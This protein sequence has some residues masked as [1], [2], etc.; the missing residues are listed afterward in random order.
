[1]NETPGVQPSTDVSRS[2]TESL[3]QREQLTLSQSYPHS[4]RSGYAIDTAI[5]SIHNGEFDARD[6]HNNLTPDST[7]PLPHSHQL[8]SSPTMV[9]HS[10]SA[11]ASSLSYQNIPQHRSLDGRKEG[12]IEEDSSEDYTSDEQDQKKAWS[13]Y[14]DLKHPHDLEDPFS[15]PKGISPRYSYPFPRDRP[16]GPTRPLISLVRNEWQQ[17]KARRS[18]SPSP[19]EDDICPEGWNEIL[20]SRTFRR[21]M[22]IYLILMVVAWVWWFNYYGPKYV[23]QSLLKESLNARRESKQGHFGMNRR[24]TFA[25]L[26]QLKQLHRRLVPGSEIEGAEKR[27]LVIVGDIHGC[28]EECKYTV[29]AM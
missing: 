7:T 9:A 19:A 13:Y 4:N 24:V 10:Y 6:R 28:L 26:T 20:C 18:R 21:W 8:P 2:S 14:S 22:V 17:R 15:N 5:R 3:E 11:R 12:R 27:R 23:E 25:G 16:S 1:M 29:S